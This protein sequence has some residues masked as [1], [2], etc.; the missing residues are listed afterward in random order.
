M[1]NTDFQLV[2]IFNPL[3]GLC[4]AFESD[5]NQYLYDEWRRRVE[6]ELDLTAKKLDDTVDLRDYD[7]ARFAVCAWIDEKV[8]NSSWAYRETWK[9]DLLQEAFYN[10]THAGEE[11]F[12]RLDGLKSTQ[13]SVRQVYLL[14]LLLGFKGRY[15]RDGDHIILQKIVDSTKKK[16]NAL[17]GVNTA[18]ATDERNVALEKYLRIRR[19]KWA[20]AG[21]FALVVSIFT[22]LVHDK[23]VSIITTQITI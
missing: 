23:Y 2:S 20:M 13:D 3:I 4:N 19:I 5:A 21:V 16:I 1:S 15:C 17:S 9:G 12:T 22:Y 7:A 8:L 14:C 10:T 11:F 18:T 6:T